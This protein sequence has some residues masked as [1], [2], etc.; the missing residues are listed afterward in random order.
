MIGAILGTP[1]IGGAIVIFSALVI[2][3]W[4]ISKFNFFQ[5]ARQDIENQ[6]GNIKAEYQRR[7]DLFMN[8]T[9]SFLADTL[10]SLIASG[11]FLVMS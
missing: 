4:G 3:G 8:L 2:L 5:S 11:T 7:W 10:Y 9:E 6:W 1:I